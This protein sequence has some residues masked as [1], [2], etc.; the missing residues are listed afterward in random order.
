MRILIALLVLLALPVQ[1]RTLTDSAGRSV[2]IPDEVNTVFAAGP[3]PRSS[4]IS[5]SPRR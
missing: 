1:A 2:E 4:S 5:S 3:P